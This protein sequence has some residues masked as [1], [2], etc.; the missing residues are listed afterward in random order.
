[1]VDPSDSNRL[2]SLAAHTIERRDAEILL[3]W[4][5][6]K[7]RAQLLASAGEPCSGR[8]RRAT[9][10]MPAVNALPACPWP[11]F[12]DAGNSGRWSSP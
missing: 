1:M 7:T 3:A 10:N 2:L 12:W 6:R 4:C 5:W 11:I 9:S 8:G